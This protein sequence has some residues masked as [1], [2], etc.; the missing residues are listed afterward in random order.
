MDRQLKRR[1]LK[2]INQ[3][4]K[5]SS[6]SIMKCLELFCGTKSFR[7]A[8]PPDWE[9]ISVDIMKKFNP[10]ICCDIL[11]LDYKALW[12]VGEFDIIWCSPP[13][14][15]FSVCRNSWIGRHVKLRKEVM[16]RELI[17]EDEIEHGLPLVRKA[18]E[19]IDYFKPSKWFLENPQTG[20]LKNHITDKP[21]IDV[22][23][24]RYGF[25]YKKRTRIWTNVDSLENQLCT[26]GVKR[27]SVRIG[28]KD[29]S[30][31]VGR[32][33]RYKIPPNLIKYLLQI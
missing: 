18:F 16:T 25:D 26:C 24:C 21:F 28:R 11:E 2:R 9:V 32:N 1:I 29:T 27:H 17:L 14:Q 33:E 15:F 3:K 19:I 23:Y 10:D 31:R 7:K 6:T 20:R 5:S 12:D 13:C 22:D 8:C 30:R 4:N